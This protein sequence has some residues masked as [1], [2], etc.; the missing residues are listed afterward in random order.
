MTGRTVAKPKA[1]ATFDSRL[2]RG[3]KQETIVTVKQ[4]MG[5]KQNYDKF[6]TQIMNIW[7]RHHLKNDE[8]SWDIRGFYEDVSKD[9]AG[10]DYGADHVELFQATRLWLLDPSLEG[11]ISSS[12]FE[13]KAGLFLSALINNGKDEDYQLKLH[14]LTQLWYVGFRNRKNIK[15]YGTLGHGCAEEMECGRI[16]VFG[17]VLSQSC[18][19][20]KNGSVIIHGSAGHVGGLIEA[21]EIR[22]TGRIDSLSKNSGQDVRI[23]QNE[24][25]IFADGK[26]VGVLNE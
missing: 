12:S 22:I 13:V 15:A 21:G 5:S 8:D 2:F 9:L 25:L 4:P 14:G 16:E 23:Y 26:L 1:D 24:K 10:L 18:Y 17:D 11:I 7:N 6:L 19:L 3:L 20:M